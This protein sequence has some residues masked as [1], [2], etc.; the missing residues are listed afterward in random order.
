MDVSTDV[1][2]GGRVLYTI[3]EI[4]A[5]SAWHAANSAPHARRAWPTRP[6]TTRDLGSAH[7]RRY[8][9]H[10]DLADVEPVLE[11]MGKGTHAEAALLAIATAIDLGS[12]ALPIEFREQSAQ[13]AK[14]QIAGEDGAG[15]AD[16][17]VFMREDSAMRDRCPV[18]I[19]DN[20]LIPQV[21][22]NTSRGERGFDIYSRLLRYLRPAYR[23]RLRH[24][25]KNLG[26]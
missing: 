24:D 19:Y 1:I 26:P 2:E 6:R 11:Q 22:E 13:G 3:G 20:Y 14:L 4:K 10:P 21:I 15:R 25:R 7:A 16:E 9:P 23:P 5:A 18:E 12:Y 8:A 17:L